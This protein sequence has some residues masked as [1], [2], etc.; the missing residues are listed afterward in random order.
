VEYFNA[1]WEYAGFKFMFDDTEILIYRAGSL[2]TSKVGVAA[3]LIAKHYH[4][5]VTPEQG[6]PHQIILPLIKI[7]EEGQEEFANY[8]LAADLEDYGRYWGVA[9][10]VGLDRKVYDVKNETLMDKPW[11]Y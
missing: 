5:L 10:F 11:K 9:Y 1:S 4:K 2:F 3:G 8:G 6:R 7:E